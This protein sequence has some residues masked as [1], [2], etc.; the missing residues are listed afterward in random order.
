MQGP[1]ITDEWN[2]NEMLI[3][4]TGQMTWTSDHK[5]KLSCSHE[6]GHF[7]PVYTEPRHKTKQNFVQILEDYQV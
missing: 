7:W 2:S 3:L 5:N 1:L 6:N 4:P